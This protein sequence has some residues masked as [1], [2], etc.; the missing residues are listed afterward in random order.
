METVCEA[1]GYQRNPTDQTPDWQCPSCGKAYVKTTHVKTARNSHDSHD[2]YESHVVYDAQDP[3]VLQDSYEPALPS[4]PIYSPASGNSLVKAAPYEESPEGFTIVICFASACLIAIPAMFLINESNRFQWPLTIL[5]LL[6]PWIALS[7]AYARRSSLLEQLGGYSSLILC[8]SLCFLMFG[9]VR[10]AINNSLAFETE[11]AWR[12]GIPI[13]FV[14]GL[15][16]AAVATRLNKEKVQQCPL[17]V[18]PALVIVAYAYGGAPVV[19]ANRWLD[20]SSPT[21]H[22][23]TVIHKY[24]SGVTD[25]KYTGGR[26][27]INYILILTPW[28]P[29]PD[30]NSLIVSRSEYDEMVPGQSV[31]CMVTHPGAIGIVWGEPLPC[32]SQAS[33]GS[34]KS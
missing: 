5:M 4:A 25:G 24:V 9:V 14:F 29:I 11:K 7:V 26:S 27:G 33:D 31:V 32:V 18:W 23:T 17:L 30:S 19:L 3:Q 20:H 16:C 15:V 12:I 28:A 34:R 2:S 10:V 8:S 6:M 13:A 21:V 22:E 1:C